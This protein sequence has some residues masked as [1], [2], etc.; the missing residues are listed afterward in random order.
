MIECKLNEL[1]EQRG[2]TQTEIANATGITR[3]TLLS[4]QL[5]HDETTRCAH[6]F[7]H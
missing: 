6:K 2:V 5:E 3:P 4:L 1:I 7:A